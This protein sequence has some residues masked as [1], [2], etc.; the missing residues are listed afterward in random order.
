MA[1]SAIGDSGKH[2]DW[3]FIYKVPKD[4]KA[5]DKSGKPATGYEYAYFDSDS[6][7]LAG[8]K[9]LLND[10]SNALHLTLQQMPASGHPTMAAVF[11]NDE[12]PSSLKKTNND[13]KGHCKGV[14]AFDSATNSAI[15]LLHSTPRYSTPGSFEFPSDELDYGQTFLCITL[16]DVKT[17][18]AI[19]T[20]MLSQQGPQTYGPALPKTAG[21]VWSNLTAGKFTLSKTPSD[22]TF[23]SKAGKKFRSIAKSRLWGQDLWSDEVGDDLGVNLDVESWRRGTI[24]STE[25]SN[26]KDDVVDVV[27]IDLGKVKFPYAWPETKDHAKWAQSI[28][29]PGKPAADWV[30]IADINRQTSQSKRGGGAICFQHPTLWKCLAQIDQ[31]TPPELKKKTKKK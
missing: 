29:T 21:S 31:V 6:K 25:D 19:A 18:E 1:L 23:T 5:A 16:K 13:D 14:L 28:E 3:W 9:H 8:S 17:A 20:Q 2:V 12:Y 26:K 10:T 22:I 4:A 30:C 15:W 24:P 7:V 27:D 11:Y